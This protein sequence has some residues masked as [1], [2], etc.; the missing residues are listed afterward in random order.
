MQAFQE[1][2]AA[3]EL[4][5]DASARADYDAAPAASA[6]AARWQAASEVD[7]EEFRRRAERLEPVIADVRQHFRNVQRQRELARQQADAGHVDWRQ[8]FRK[9]ARDSLQ[10]WVAMPFLFLAGTWLLRLTASTPSGQSP[11]A[12]HNNSHKGA[13]PQ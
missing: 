7:P 13:D 10:Y 1:A 8:V 4:L 12:A 2:C 11:Y 6:A 9:A 5:K 3:F